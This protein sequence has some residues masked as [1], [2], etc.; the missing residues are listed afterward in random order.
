[1]WLTGARSCSLNSIHLSGFRA[2]NEGGNSKI[3]L[4]PCFNFNNVTVKQIFQC[5]NV[6]EAL[7]LDIKKHEVKEKSKREREYT[8]IHKIEK[9]KY[10]NKLAY[11]QRNHAN[12]QTKVYTSHSFN[13]LHAKNF[14]YLISRFPSLTHF[15]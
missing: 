2:E 13:L 14:L 10:I 5:P 1:M 6:T 9:L 3:E 7:K 15:K 12:S 8:Q 4:V 11:K